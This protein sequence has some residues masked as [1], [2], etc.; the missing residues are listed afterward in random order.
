MTWPEH[1]DIS[2]HGYAGFRLFG[3]ETNGPCLKLSRGE[4]S[5]CGV[6]RGVGEQHLA[7]H[8]VESDR[9]ALVANFGGYTSAGLLG[10]SY[11]EVVVLCGLSMM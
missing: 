8:R 9:C 5:G 10:I 2:S 7:Q 6:C 4:G 11:L 1:H 3:P